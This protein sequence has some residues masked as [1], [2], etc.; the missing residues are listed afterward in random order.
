MISLTNDRSETAESVNTEACSTSAAP[1]PVKPLSIRIV[2]I[3]GGG[4]NAIAHMA[5]TDLRELRPVALHTSARILELTTAPEKFLL[6]ADL[7][8]GLG[9][10][11]DPSLA[12]AAAERDVLALKKLCEGVDLLFIV[13]GLGGGTGSGAAPV[14]ARIAKEC[15]A[16]V[17]GVVTL[18]FELEG[19]RRRH[20]AE[21][22]LHDLKAAA[23]AVI[24]LPNQKIFRIVDEKTSVL[25]SLKITNELL[26]QG[27]RGIWQM[28][29]R[30]GLIHVDFADL[31]AVLRD[32]HAESSFA[33]AEA[34]GEGR[35]REIIEQLLASPLIEGGQALTDADAVLVNLVGGADLSMADVKRIMEEINRR[36]HDA[37]LIMGASIAENS[38]GR[39]ALTLVA[40][41]RSVPPQADQAATGD[42]FQGS[43]PSLSLPTNEPENRFLQQNPSENGNSRITA[44]SPEVALEGGRE[45]QKQ[46]SSKS[47]KPAVRLRQTE[48]PLQIVS[49][50]R[51]EKS[52]PTIHRGEDLD[53]PT[54]IRRGIPLN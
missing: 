4:G 8:Q 39:I 15:G 53:V 5:E 35:A 26:S 25:E 27:I 50:G 1:P 45:P 38:Q 19:A 17:L 30:P 16:L 12:R 37:H 41:R 21:Q 44:P 2:G 7:T 13:A 14:L 24:C 54:Y 36:T 28:L 47:S 48:M 10:G 31:S 18:P 51:F 23:D 52:H 29:A 32:R 42:R 6:G 11:G 20:H 43:S 33:T 22:A 40:S 3:G 9:A 46:S 49:K 34:Q